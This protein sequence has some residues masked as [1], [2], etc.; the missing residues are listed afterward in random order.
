MCTPFYFFIFLYEKQFF[1][2]S[3]CFF[4]SLLVERRV[5]STIQF[6]TVISLSFGP[7]ADSS[8][9]GTG[10]LGGGRGGGVAVI[11]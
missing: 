5:P 7:E 11:T 2:F 8:V 10:L 9:F 6:Y 4:P 3:F 1:F